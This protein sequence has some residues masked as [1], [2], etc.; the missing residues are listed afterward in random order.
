MP[1]WRG[2]LGESASSL[3]R[4]VSVLWHQPKF[5]FLRNSKSFANHVALGS[6]R[7]WTFSSRHQQ[8]ADGGFSFGSTEIARPICVTH[9]IVEVRYRTDRFSAVGYF[10]LLWRAGKSLIQNFCRSTVRVALGVN[11]GCWPLASQPG[12]T[13]SNTACSNVQSANTRRR[14]FWHPTRSDRARRNGRT[15]IYSR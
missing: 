6:A 3:C 15:V 5:V 9:L 1:L 14:R 13:V 8:N 12:R 10:L 4:P 2:P 7:E 11:C